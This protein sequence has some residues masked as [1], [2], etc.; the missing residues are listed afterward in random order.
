MGIYVLLVIIFLLFFVGTEKVINHFFDTEE[1]LVV[2]TRALIRREMSLLNYLE[3][4]YFLFIILVS[5]SFLLTYL[6]YLFW[7]AV[8]I[9]VA[10]FVI[11][12][13]FF[14]SEQSEI[15]K[16]KK[17]QTR[18]MLESMIDDIKKM[19]QIKEVLNVKTEDKRDNIKEYI[20]PFVI[21]SA[22]FFDG[23]KREQF[24]YSLRKR[25]REE[26]TQMKW[27]DS[28]GNSTLFVFINE[29]NVDE[30]EVTIAIC[31]NLETKE[32]VNYYLRQQKDKNKPSS[33]EDEDF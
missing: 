8:L 11:G 25:F 24:L 19:S 22:Y 26:S 18:K 23:E 12:F 3:H 30:L 7:I 15:M 32:A 5:V 27:I 20:Y 28:Q 16:Q 6:L 29:K 17:I 4:W 14:T 1:E 31:S 2:Q 10:I 21:E 13:L 9:I 33:I